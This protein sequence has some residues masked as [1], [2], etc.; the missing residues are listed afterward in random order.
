MCD[1]FLRYAHDI[2]KNKI[3]SNEEP[4][5]HFRDDGMHVRIS[6]DHCVLDC[7]LATTTIPFG[8]QHL[9]EERHNSTSI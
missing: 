1:G 6:R 7:D 8:A 9:N 3:T 2:T 4:L 5:N